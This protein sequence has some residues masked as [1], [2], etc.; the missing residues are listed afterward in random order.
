[1]AFKFGPAEYFSLMV[2]GLVGAVV[3]ASG[4]LIKAVGMILLGLLLGLVG[5]DVNSGVARFTFDIPELTDG[6]DFV[7]I[8]MGDLRLRRNH[9]QPRARRATREVFLNKVTALFPTRRTSG[10]CCLAVLRGTA[11]GSILGILPGGGAVLSSFASYTLE[12]K[13]SKL[14]GGVRQ[15]RDRR[16]RR[17]RNRPTTPA[18]RPPSFRC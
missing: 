1:M 18:R 4:S 6:I 2:L 11:L 12:K 14:P 15:G 5:T 7:A 10:A 13:M 17:R 8:A 16:R 9:Q 3:L